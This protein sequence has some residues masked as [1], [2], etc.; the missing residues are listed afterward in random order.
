MKL[1]IT[2]AQKLI[3]SLLVLA[4][5]VVGFMI[6]LPAMFRHHDREMHAAFYFLAAAFFSLLYAGRNFWIHLFI[7]AALAAFGAGIEYAQEFSNRLVRHPF[8]GRFDSEDVKY[9]FIGLLAFSVIWLT[10][11]LGAWL[12][13]APKPGKNSVEEK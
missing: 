9:N 10:Y 7:L 3:I 13:K 4:C 8:H 1:K 11:L 5:S 6:K 2:R 12:L